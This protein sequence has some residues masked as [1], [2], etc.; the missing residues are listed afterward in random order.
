[1]GGRY[2]ITSFI[3]RGAMD[4]LSVTVPYGDPN[5]RAL[6]GTLAIPEPGQPN[7]ALALSE[8]FGLHPSL[9]TPR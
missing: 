8:G 1:M 4:G 5:Y 7:G 3:A 6:R 2:R 9:T